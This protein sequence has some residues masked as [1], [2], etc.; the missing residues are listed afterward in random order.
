[1]AEK[2]LL[3]KHG[4]KATAKEVVAELGGS[5]AG[6]TEEKIKEIKKISLDIVSLD[7][8]ISTND[9]N[10]FGGFLKEENS[11]APD[12]AVIDEEKERVIKEVL[13]ENLTDNL[14]REFVKMKFGLSPYSPMSIDEIAKNFKKSKDDIKQL[15]IKVFR[16]LKASHILTKLKNFYYS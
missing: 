14:E 8:N 5:A 16:K 2:V 3:E 9:D 15:E 4:R 13:E 12:A 10:N 6:F 7:K 1:V 11:I